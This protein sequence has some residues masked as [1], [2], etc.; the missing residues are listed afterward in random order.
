MA[1]HMRGYRRRWGRFQSTCRF[2]VI[3][4]GSFDSVKF[5]GRVNESAREALEWQ[6]YFSWEHIA[7][8]N[9]ESQGAAILS[10]LVSSFRNSLRSIPPPT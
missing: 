7:G 1:A 10:R 8:S 2:V 3:W 9:G 5:C 4:R 6:E